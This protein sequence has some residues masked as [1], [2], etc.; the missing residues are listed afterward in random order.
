MTMQKDSARLSRRQAIGLLGMGAG[1]G[2]VAA[3]RE[4]LALAASWQA[5][6]RGATKV[7]FPKAAIIRTILRDVSPEALGNGATLFHEHL[8]ISDP[9]PPWVT[10]PRDARPSYTTNLD[11]MVDEI[12]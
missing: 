1:F 4:E 9:L 8:S 3:L 6:P 12:K 2:A 7:T 11:L 5:A 10:P